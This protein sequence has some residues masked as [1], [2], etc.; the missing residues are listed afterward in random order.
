MSKKILMI[1]D[2][3]ELCEEMKDILSDE[4]YSV[5]TAFDSSQGEK[6]IEKNS[7]DI[8]LLDIKL[9]GLNGID[10]LRNLSKKKPAIK[11][12]IISGRPFTE[13]ILS[14]ENLM[15]LVSGVMIKPFDVRLLLEKIKASFNCK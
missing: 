9:P 13:R 14:E 5:H 10:M 15:S 12:F 8:L 6:L 11:I 3:A 1:D 7:Y 4:G 2:D